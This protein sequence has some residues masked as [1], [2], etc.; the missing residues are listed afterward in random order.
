MASSTGTM[1]GARSYRSSM[2]GRSL[3]EARGSVT[4]SWSASVR[5]LSSTSSWKNGEA[6]RSTPSRGGAGGLRDIGLP[7]KRG[8]KSDAAG[9]EAD[10]LQRLA[11]HVVGFEQAVL[12]V[13]G[14]RRRY[15]LD[16]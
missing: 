11:Q 1:L 8:Q 16:A 9:L 14:E 4:N 7:Q 13:L 15:Q 10:G 12:F 6:G 5:P 3:R 2:T